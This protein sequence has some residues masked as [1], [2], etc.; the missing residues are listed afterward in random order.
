MRV[1]KNIIICIIISLIIQ[2]S[3]LFYI[4]NFFLDSSF[5]L[6]SQKI[7]DLMT[8]AKINIPNNALNIN[9]SFDAAYI[10]YYLNNE[11]FVVDTKSGKST[12]LSYSNN[13]KVSFYKWLPD[14]NRILIAEKDKN[15]LSISYYDIDKGQMDNITKFPMLSSK[16]E[17]VDIVASPLINVIYIKVENGPQRVSVYWV[18]VM[19]SEKRIST[20]TNNIGNIEAIPHEDKMVYEN[21]TDNM[22]YATGSRSA[23]EFN[24]TTKLSLLKVDNNDMVYIGAIDNNN[25]INKIY[26]GTLNENTASWGVLNFGIPVNR[27][28]LFITASGAV[29]VNNNLKGTI[30]DINTGK[31][32][33]YRGSFLQLYSDGIASL[34][35][36]TLVKTLFK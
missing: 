15:N 31:G 8:N 17:V 29:Y 22:I 36:G 6:K 35:K 27:N 34:N 19:K 20:R 30:T 9:T 18:N 10:A 7:V 32:L 5:A 33:A 12:N 28:N 21:L 14:R 16:S 11:L 1:I 25:N 24:G 4:D 13:I 2:L 26:F 3:G 23:L